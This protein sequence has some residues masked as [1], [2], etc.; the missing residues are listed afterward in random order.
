VLA[1]KSGQ[2]IMG[3]CPPEQMTTL[4]LVRTQLE[5]EAA[6]FRDRATRAEGWLQTIHSE[7]EQKL[8]APRS[9]SGTE[10]KFITSNSNT[11]PSQPPAA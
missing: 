9:A 1:D 5:A 8:I 4:E 2:R 11:E 3:A 6:L 10:Q 7:I